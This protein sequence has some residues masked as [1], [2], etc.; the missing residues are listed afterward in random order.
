M[1][2]ATVLPQV[3]D[4][5]PV[6]I[7]TANVSANNYDANGLA[8]WETLGLTGAGQTV[9]IIDSGIAYDHIALGEGWGPNSRVVGGWD[10]AENDADPY[11]DYGARSF[12]SGHGTHVAGIIGGND[13]LHPGLATQVDMVSLR[14]FDDEGK[15]YFTWVEQAL[16]WV[17]ENVYTF[18]NPITTVNLSLGANLQSQGAEGWHI[19]ED[20]LARLNEMGIFISVAA[21]NSFQTVVSP[22]SLS[23]PASSEWVVPVSSS[24]AD[25]ALSSFSQR[26]SRVLVAPGENV[27]SS[28]PDYLGGMTAYGGY[29]GFNGLQDDFN[30]MTG[31][32]MAAPYVA[33]ASILLREAMQAM[34]RTDIQQDDLYLVM[35]STADVFHDPVTGTDYHHLNLSRALA[36]ILLEDEAG[37][38]PATATDLWL[39]TGSSTRTGVLQNLHD[40]DVF[41]YTAGE[42]GRIQLRFGTSSGTTP[43][44]FL[45]RDGSRELL[46][47]ADSWEFDVEAGS[48]FVLE[49]VPDGGIGSYEYTVEFQPGLP[50]AHTDLGPIEF[51]DWQDITVE[52]GERWFQLS[53]A[54]DGMFTAEFLVQNLDAV[55]GL[56]IHDPQGN[57]LAS[58]HGTGSVRVDLD[59]SAGEPL[60]LRITSNVA[61]GELRLAN[62]VSFQSGGEEVHVWGGDAGM[63]AGLSLIDTPHLEIQGVH[64]AL[65]E[66]GARIRWA[67]ESTAPPEF[68]I[69]GSPHQERV[70]FDEGQIIVSSATSSGTFRLNDFTNVQFVGGSED[71]VVLRGRSGATSLEAT[72]QHLVFTDDEHTFTFA[73]VGRILVEAL[74]PGA[75]QALLID[76]PA[77]D[78][79]HF[80]SDS[81]RMWS[82][83]YDI[84]TRGFESTTV[85]AT[86]GGFD[87]ASLFDSPRDD[88][89]RASP[90][91]AEMSA[92]GRQLRIVDFDQV[93]AYATQG[94]DRAE[95]DDSS[96]SDTFKA[97][98]RWSALFGVG[99]SLQT[100]D[101][102]Q[103]QARSTR[104]GNDKAQFVGSDAEE[105]FA[106]N[107]DVSAMRGANFLRQSSGFQ[108]VRVESRGGSDQAHLSASPTMRPVGTSEAWIRVSYPA[109]EIVLEGFESVLSDIARATPELQERDAVDLLLQTASTEP[110]TWPWSL[111][112]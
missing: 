11:D 48:T 36:E 82:Q 86:A 57:L 24:A 96:G 106:S 84:V 29:T 30:T 58:S 46:S 53:A 52:R 3:Q 5:L 34:G 69:V 12:A 72:A 92:A 103:V 74:Q 104:G 22:T 59:V 63:S 99:F 71:A 51:L 6:E 9:A 85:H 70:N 67:G 47:Q 23:Y 41:R 21:G 27:I 17:E 87:K 93:I 7:Q 98:P 19:L 111:P 89:F 49:F 81:T 110:W 54:H 50:V 42:A 78:V 10:F 68:I 14:V 32:S 60:L 75:N 101:F 40:V 112:Q 25:G 62:L 97:S 44:V 94:V 18:E 66:P 108:Q 95:L 1:L 56:E 28:V 38:S 105:I 102:E 65:P 35:R 8:G 4:T 90:R 79:L 73:A 61:H 45:E 31:T 16:Q 100:F 107:G 2:A 20:D 88:V 91:F 15:G 26:N 43:R 13:P 109:A 37:D 64:Y 39:E 77:D 83:T 55:L 76:S 80:T 33:G